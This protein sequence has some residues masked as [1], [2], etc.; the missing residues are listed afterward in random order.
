M[1]QSTS[2]VLTMLSLNNQLSLS[3]CHHILFCWSW[4]R[5]TSD[6]QFEV[7]LNCCFRVPSNAGC[8]QENGL[9]ACRKQRCNRR[10]K[11]VDVLLKL[12]RFVMFLRSIW[13]F[14][15]CWVF[16]WMKHAFYCFLR[17]CFQPLYKWR[18]A[19]L[20]S[21]WLALVMPTPGGLWFRNPA[22]TPVPVSQFVGLRNPSKKGVKEKNNPISIY[23]SICFHHCLVSIYFLS[24]KKMRP[25]L[26]HVIRRKRWCL[27]SWRSIFVGRCDAG[28]EGMTSRNQTNKP[29]AIS[30]ILLTSS[31]HIIHR[32]V[33]GV[34]VGLAFCSVRWWF[35][36]VIH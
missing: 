8:P 10:K 14:H 29:S 11:H 18:T 19:Q 28:W 2:M 26:R 27:P 6:F 15:F 12:F 24:A 9:N 30:G 13:C 31:T 4:T 22:S 33:Y 32:D 7:Q 21:P 1:L 5:E 17:C 20:T 25:T 35:Q 36:F 3:I 16:G 23:F 34:G